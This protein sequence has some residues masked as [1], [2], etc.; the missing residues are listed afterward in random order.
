MFILF[1]YPK[2]RERRKKVWGV[3][4]PPTPPKTPPFSKKGAKLE[5]FARFARKGEK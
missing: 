5:E 3:A 2:E 4:I 1:L